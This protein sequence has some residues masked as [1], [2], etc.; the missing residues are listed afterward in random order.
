MRILALLVVL[1][2]PSLLSAD[3]LDSLKAELTGE[4]PNEAL[5]I[6]QNELRES[7]GLDSMQF[8]AL[9]D[10]GQRT[11]LPEPWHGRLQN[12]M[13]YAHARFLDFN[14]R[15][16]PALTIYN[17]LSRTLRPK[18]DAELLSRVYEN[19][20]SLF[21][22]MGSPSKSLECALHALEVFPEDGDL[23]GKIHILNSLGETHRQIEKYDAAIGNYETALPLARQ[24]P[25]RNLESML[26]NNLGIAQTK[27]GQYAAAEET[28]LRGLSICEEIDSDFGRSRL[29]T[30]LGFLY[31]DQGIYDRALEYYSRSI[32]VKKK[33][34]SK[35][36]LAYSLNDY[37]E[38]LAAIGRFDE[39]LSYSHRALKI[40]QQEN[41]IYYE[42]DMYRTLSSTYKKMGHYDSAY[43]FLER[44]QA[45]QDSVMNED[46][47]LEIAR[48]ERL[49]EIMEKDL[50]NKVLKSQNEIGQL[51][52]SRQTWI[53]A[54]FL[55]LSLALALIGLFFYRSSSERKRLLAKVEAQNTSLDSKN[56]S[57]QRL[58]EEQESL[59]NIVAH[60]L[61]AP[62]ANIIGLINLD[63]VESPETKDSENRYWM[64]RSAENALHFIAEFNMLHELE[65][66]KE[67]PPLASFDLVELV[68]D[69][70]SQYHFLIE[71]KRI[72]I[73]FNPPET[74]V[75]D[76]VKTHVRHILLNIISN[77]IKFSPEGGSLFIAISQREELRISVQDQGPGIPEENMDRIFQKFFR[78]TAGNATVQTSNGLGLSLVKLL[79]DRL[80]GRIKVKS[81]TT[82][83]TE[84]IIYLP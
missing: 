64:Q 1:F 9:L 3:P 37:G 26:L 19:L 43:F 51:L 30:N 49:S 60:D 33:L 31:N 61:K 42:R 72:S 46:Q 84:F 35:V 62:L 63:K 45:L 10:L 80:N 78:T 36:S 54:T 21:L 75:V 34:K 50:E 39:A 59:F 69:V 66:K 47:A 7:K 52:I 41:A 44:Y 12:E 65:S 79:V 32:A 27:L 24:Q 2:F 74:L 29:L 16:E 48:L 13:R 68:G 77:A 11:S 23:A 20:S 28:L 71:S 81:S 18:E 73:H 56:A 53:I 67:L 22:D 14:G 4:E 25:N 70:C 15:S 8:F 58:L 82:D 38:V 76:S 6:L 5:A 55:L 57:L 40:A 83:G 17:E